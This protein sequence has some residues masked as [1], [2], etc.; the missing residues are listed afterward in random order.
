MSQG[1][2][3]TGSNQRGVIALRERIRKLSKRNDDARDLIATRRP[4]SRSSKL[5]VFPR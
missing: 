1:T 4:L 3:T 5:G 2:A